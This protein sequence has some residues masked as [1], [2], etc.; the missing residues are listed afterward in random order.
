MFCLTLFFNIL[1]PF[2][3]NSDVDMDYIPD[4]NNSNSSSDSEL[5]IAENEPR[6]STSKKRTR[7]I[8]QW[9]RSEAK[10]KR[11]TG[12]RYVGREGEVHEEKFS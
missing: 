6:P 9:K 2:G 5:S 7:K 8:A 3:D 4:K 10:L 1:E 11:N 12:Q